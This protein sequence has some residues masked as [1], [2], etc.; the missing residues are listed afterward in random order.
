[1]YET[2]KPKQITVPK[3]D[4]SLNKMLKCGI[5]VVKAMFEMSKHDFEQRNGEPCLCIRHGEI[6]FRYPKDPISGLP[7]LTFPLKSRQD[8]LLL[9]E[10]VGLACEFEPSVFPLWLV[11]MIRSIEVKDVKFGYDDVKFFSRK[12]WIFQR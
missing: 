6:H 10:K 8:S 3:P 11:V 7:T 4:D 2:F 1:M 9:I 12:Q 5:E